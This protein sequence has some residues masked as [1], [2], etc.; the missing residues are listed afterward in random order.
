M[1]DYAFLDAG[2]FT[3]NCIYP[4]SSIREAS[5]S[6]LSSEN[7]LGCGET[8]YTWYIDNSGSAEAQ[9]ASSIILDDYS[10]NLFTEQEYAEKI[11]KVSEPKLLHL[12]LFAFFL[13]ARNKVKE[14]S[15]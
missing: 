1:L 5:D 14:N 10:I 3:L 13:I 7:L 6:L 4:T 12:M 15:V 8:L 11:S 9:V 2:L